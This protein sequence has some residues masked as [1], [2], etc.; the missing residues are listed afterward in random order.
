MTQRK[1]GINDNNGQQRPPRTIINNNWI[2]HPTMIEDKPWQLVTAKTSS[3]NTHTLEFLFFSWQQQ[4]H[5]TLQW[6]SN[7]TNPLVLSFAI[8]L[9]ITT[10]FQTFPSNPNGMSC[11]AHFFWAFVPWGTCHTW[12]N[13]VSCSFSWSFVATHLTQFTHTV[14]VDGSYSCQCRWD[15]FPVPIVFVI[16]VFTTTISWLF[17]HTESYN[18]TTNFSLFAKIAFGNRWTARGAFLCHHLTEFK[19]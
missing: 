18:L 7:V 2:Q 10:G 13:G 11:L 14:Q 19:H 16:V 6:N 17:G 9:W 4:P 5:T 8:L 15:R 3:L 12:Q 1:T